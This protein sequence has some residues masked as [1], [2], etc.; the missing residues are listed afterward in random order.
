MM[1][2]LGNGCVPGPLPFWDVKPSSCCTLRRA[3]LPIARQQH[4]PV[5]WHLT[6]LGF[7]LA[8][9]NKVLLYHLLLLFQEGC[10]LIKMQL[11]ISLC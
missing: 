1:G 9:I 11:P 2:A 7:C 8:S 5:S 3:V 6:W 4:H 10:S